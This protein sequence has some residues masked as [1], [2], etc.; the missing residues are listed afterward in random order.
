M[1]SSLLLHQLMAV[2]YA[3]CTE[4]QSNPQTQGPEDPD[5][6][7]STQS[8]SEASGEPSMD[9]MKPLFPGLNDLSGSWNDDFLSNRRVIAEI[10]ANLS[11][12]ESITP[13]DFN[14]VL[15]KEMEASHRAPPKIL[16]NEK[17]AG[18]SN[19]VEKLDKASLYK[20][21]AE[22]LDVPDN[23]HLVRHVAKIAQNNGF[24]FGWFPFSEISVHLIEKLK[25]AILEPKYTDNLVKV[26]ED[27]SAECERKCGEIKEDSADSDFIK[28]FL[29]DD[30]LRTKLPDL[31]ASLE[32]EVKNCY[33]LAKESPNKYK[34]EH[35]YT[36][37]CCYQAI[38][39][40][41]ES[42]IAIKDYK[43]RS[44][45][46]SIGG[47]SL[48]VLPRPCVF[49]KKLAEVAL[50]MFM[51]AIGRNNAYYKKLTSRVEKTRSWWLYSHNITGVSG[52]TEE[53]D[54]ILVKL[55]G[56]S[57]QID[58][59]EGEADF[60]DTDLPIKIESLNQVL[61]E[62]E[63]LS[64]DSPSLTAKVRETRE[65]LN[66]ICGKAEDGQSLMSPSQLDD[67]M[68]TLMMVL[69]SILFVC[70]LGL[71]VYTLVKFSKV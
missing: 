54:A 32:K 65:R 37:E 47:V 39:A 43:K 56:I 50:N 38:K 30:L 66:K 28:S 49:S 9:T 25:S 2:H 58:Q 63:R 13:E 24:S 16:V 18:V 8:S 33:D 40:M 45:E 7:D 42:V 52:P 59:L 62:L 57:V 12:Q 4:P 35:L 10:L 11:K 21:L 46:I 17:F 64:D 15:E 69:M 51:F 67:E 1:R 68:S 6:V 60:K 19:L 22:D 14:S 5:A 48:G 53:R 41:V 44:Y 55:D 71:A 70:F 3:S 23:T 31:L 36:A 29:E 27:I 61:N 26:L 34:E 20:T